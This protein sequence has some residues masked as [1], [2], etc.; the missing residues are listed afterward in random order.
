MS[1]FEFDFVLRAQDER[2]VCGIDEVS[3]GE[4][5]MIL[6]LLCGESVSPCSEFENLCISRGYEE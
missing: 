4:G 2:K 1:A 6:D 5:D 3:C